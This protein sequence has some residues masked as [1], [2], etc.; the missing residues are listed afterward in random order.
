MID[1]SYLTETQ[2]KSMIQSEPY[3]GTIFLAKDEDTRI[4]VYNIEVGE[5]NVYIHKTRTQPVSFVCTKKDIEKEL[6]K[7]KVIDLLNTP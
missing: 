1:L 5:F 6:F 3:S 4:H 2:L 7:Y